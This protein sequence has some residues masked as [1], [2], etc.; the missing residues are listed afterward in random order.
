[1]YT[2]DENHSTRRN[3]QSRLWGQRERSAFARASVTLRYCSSFDLSILADNISQR[4]L[5]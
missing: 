3:G 1:M 5:I 4:V 2:S